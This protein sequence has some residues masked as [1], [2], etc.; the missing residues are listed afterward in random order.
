MN[1]S[2]CDC[3]IFPGAKGA[4]GYGR[5]LHK[6]KNRL[7]HRISYCTFHGIELE[8]IEGLVVMHT[9]DN[10]PCVNPDHLVLGTQAQNNADKKIKGRAARLFGNKNR[11]KLSEGQV[12]EIKSRYVCRCKKNGSAALA[13]DFGVSRSTIGMI[14][15][16]RNWREV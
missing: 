13:K 7:A 8:S 3:M 6:G 2:K 12:A 5:K 14:L 9:C 1:Y 10:P 15:S 11:S 16:G 4:G